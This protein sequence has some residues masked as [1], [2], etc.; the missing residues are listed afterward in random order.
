MI[1]YEEREET[2]AEMRARKEE[3]E[4]EALAKAGGKKPPPAKGKEEEEEKREMVKEATVHS[5][6]MGFL[7]PLYAKWATSQFQFA[8]DRSLRDLATKEPIHK[9]IFPQQDG[10]PV[11][12]PS[13]KY[14]VKLLFLGRE[15]L[16]EVDDRMPCDKR[17]KLLFPRTVEVFEIWPQLLLKAYL[18]VYSYKWLPAAH[19]EEEVGDGALIYALTGLLPERVRLD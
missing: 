5:M 2:D 10:V 17:K 7:M 4:K 14:W 12:S 6:D 3:A 11:L 8:K 13:G 16:V 19:I 9:R 18:K 1:Y 15:R